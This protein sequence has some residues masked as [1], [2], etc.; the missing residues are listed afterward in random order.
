MHICLD[1]VSG[2][3]GLTPSCLPRLCL[4]WLATK[5]QLSL[6]M[7]GVPE[8]LWTKRMGMQGGTSGPMPARKHSFE[9]QGVNTLCMQRQRTLGFGV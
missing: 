6:K 2:G 4:E 1:L 7:V 5:P 8:E 3:S 9:E